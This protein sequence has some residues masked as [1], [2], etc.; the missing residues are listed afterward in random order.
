[1]HAEIERR[2]QGSY[3][4]VQCDDEGDRRVP[5]GFPVLR[6]KSLQAARRYQHLFVP[7]SALRLPEAAKPEKI[8]LG[9]ER[10][11]SS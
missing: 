6:T 1:M 2:R 3:A 7:C 11:A 10:G 9:R 5:F 4:L 8:S